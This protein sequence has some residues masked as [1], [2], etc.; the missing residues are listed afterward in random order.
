MVAQ[1]ESGV[2]RKEHHEGT[3]HSKQAGVGTEEAGLGAEGAP[4]TRAMK[5]NDWLLSDTCTS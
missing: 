2:G 5:I 1:Q 3:L 4:V